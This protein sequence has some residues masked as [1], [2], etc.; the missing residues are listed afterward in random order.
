VPQKGAGRFN[1]FVVLCTFDLLAAKRTKGEAK[2][3]DLRKKDLRASLRNREAIASPN[4]EGAVDAP[5]APFYNIVDGG[6]K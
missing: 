1:D 4:S 6:D 3:T 5:H 2:G